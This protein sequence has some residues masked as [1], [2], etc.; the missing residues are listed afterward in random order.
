MKKSSSNNYD[1]LFIAF[2]SGA[3]TMVVEIAG[4]RL[5]SPYLGNTIY[6]WA[7]AIGFVL[8]ALAIGYYVGGRLAD[9]YQDRKHFSTILLAAGICTALIPLLGN[10]LVPATLFLEL[11][12]ANIVAALI[13]VPASFF[14]GMVSPY[15]I[16]LTSV[17]G[18]EGQSAG[19]VFAISTFGSIIGALGTGFILIPN[20]GVTYIFVFCALA[21]LVAAWVAFRDRSLPTLAGSACIFFFVLL[22]LQST[23]ANYLGGTVIYEEDSP[24]YHIRILEKNISGEPAKV[25]IL[26]NAYS[27]AERTDGSMVF[28]YTK[29]SR[30]GYEL[31]E[32]VENALV[33]GVAGGTQV[34]DLKNYYP[35]AHIHGVEIDPS[36]PKI[37]KEHFSLEEDSSTTIII[38]DARRHL[39]T[40]NITYEL[41]IIDVFR[42][43]SFPPHL[44]TQ[45]FLQELKEDLSP[46]GVVIVNLISAIEGEDSMAFLLLYNT[47][48]SVFENT[49]VFPLGDDPSSVQNIILIATDKETSAFE[50][51]Y[52]EEIYSGVVPQ[53]QV[54]TDELNPI[55]IYLSH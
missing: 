16:K 22:S 15:A 38:E 24:Y 25:L 51:K 31:A 20:L 4:A 49:V 41:V 9:F 18:E 8:A 45:E 50:Q 46:E 10:I 32:E 34:E 1:I 47:F 19:R 53:T 48:A 44:S 27:S 5:I 52:S 33:L 17:A 36:L 13:L 11:S 43:K 30:V 21:M 23:H 40:N 26:D 7:S 42:G 28:E 35:A 39:K 12:A 3:A 37:A 6:T 54:L 14:Y 29:K 55:E 2:V